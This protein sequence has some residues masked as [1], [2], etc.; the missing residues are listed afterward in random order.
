MNK[1]TYPLLP[2]TVTFHT[3]LLEDSVYSSDVLGIVQRYFLEKVSINI[4][5]RLC[6]RD[7]IPKDLK[8]P[9]NVA[10]CERT[11][12]EQVNARLSNAG[13][14]SS[15]GAPI[16]KKAYED[17]YEHKGFSDVDAQRGTIYLVTSSY[18]K[19]E[20]EI[21]KHSGL[22][23]STVVELDGMLFRAADYLIMPPTEYDYNQTFAS[24]LVN[25]ISDIAGVKP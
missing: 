23:R 10:V 13:I 21:A 22:T 8:R 16:L 1:T 5:F 12:D 17:A 15:E 25:A 20:F 6:E 14:S 11:L 24:R 4:E 19:I 2:E 18:E 3:A 9:L 7:E